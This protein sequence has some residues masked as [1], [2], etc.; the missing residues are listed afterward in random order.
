MDLL[1]AT[2][3]PDKVRELMALLDEQPLH[4]RTLVNFPAIGEVKEDGATFEENARA[5]A[6]FCAERSGLLTI[7]DDSGLEVDALNGRPGVLSARYAPTSSARIQKLLAELNA[8]PAGKRRARF[9][10]AMAL[11]HPDGQS[12]VRCGYCD[13]EIAREPRGSGGFGYDPIFY[14]PELGKT[15]AE[16]TL[17][18][19]NQ[20]SHR[21]LALRQIIVLLKKMID[22]NATFGDLLSL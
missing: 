22:N 10:C 5:K 8:V 3:N 6:C 13:G 11:A 1:L 15:M 17:E 18:E 16:L 7:A 21:S 14:L 4:I 20:L 12:L 19:K 2:N 9:V